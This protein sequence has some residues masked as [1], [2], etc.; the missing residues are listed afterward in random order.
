MKSIVVANVGNSDLGKGDETYFDIRKDN[1]Y[2]KSK[3]FYESNNFNFEAILLEPLIKELIKDFEIEWIY[4]F[5]TEQRP[6]HPKDTIY[7]AKIIKEILTKRFQIENIELVYIHENPS[8]YDKMFTIYE[9][10]IEK[11]SSDADVIHVSIT[12]GTSAQNT[13]LLIHSLLKFGNRVQAIYK[14]MGVKEPKKFKIGEEIARILLYEQVKALESK[15]LY[16]A[17]V[18]IAERYNLLTNKDIHILRSKEH[19]ALFDFEACIKDLEKV[20]D[21]TFGE[22]KV[23]VKKEIEEINRLKEGL[24]NKEPFSEEYFLTYKALIKELCTNMK[25]KW[26]Q[27]AYADFLGRLFR[28]EEALLRYVFEKETNVTTKKI[29]EEYKDFERYVNDNEELL[30][31]LGK[32]GIKLEHIEPNRRVLRKILEFWVTKKAK[33]KLGII[34]RFVKKINEPEGNSLAD[35]RNKSILAHGFEGI[36]KDDFEKY[37]DILDDIQNISRWLE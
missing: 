14:P 5:A 27:R 28:F 26:G 15:H 10:E 13:A 21:A 25:L 2:E 33:Q 7:V 16:S 36:S 32:N 35:L 18:E 31:F 30:D 37:K 19:R 17:A 29:K 11:M 6:F 9:N 3:E 4:L 34:Y 24:K 20:S 12:G 23:R 22:E 8:D 1:I